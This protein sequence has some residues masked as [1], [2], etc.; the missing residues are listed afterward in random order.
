M[1]LRLGMVRH[2]RG[3]QL[4]LPNFLISKMLRNVIPSSH[5]FQ[6]EKNKITTNLIKIFNCILFSILELGSI[7]FCILQNRMNG[8]MSSTEGIGIK[9]NIK[10]RKEQK[11]AE[12]NRKHMGHCKSIL[13]RIKMERASLECWLRGMPPLIGAWESPLL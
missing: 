4:P 7:L 9:Q 13:Y 2:P 10:G 1:L 6:S 5:A 11:E 3:I 12:T 8:P